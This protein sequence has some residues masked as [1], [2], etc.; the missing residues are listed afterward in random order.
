M[1]TS[2]RCYDMQSPETKRSA[3][4]V[5]SED[6]QPQ[7]IRT[8]RTHIKRPFTTDRYHSPSRESMYHYTWTDGS[9]SKD[10]QEMVLAIIPAY[11]L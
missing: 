7:E 4:W 1:I 11:P 2:D 8:G 3:E 9:K 6:S 10:E 5:R